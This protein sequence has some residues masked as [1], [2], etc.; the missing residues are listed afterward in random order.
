MRRTLAGLA[1]ALLVAMPV[2]AARPNGMTATVWWSDYQ[3]PVEQQTP[4]GALQPDRSLWVVNSTPC[5][6][7]ADDEIN[8]IFGGT[9]LAGASYTYTT[10]LIADWTGHLI[11]VRSGNPNIAASVAVDGVVSVTQGCIVGPEYER[12]A[13]AGFVA[14][15]GSN[16]GVGVR[17]TV[18][19]TI[20]NLTGRRLHRVSAEGAIE[21]HTGAA[22]AYWCPASLVRG[23][24]YPGPTWYWS[25]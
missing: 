11:G 12:D 8:L 5:I 17:H 13:Y 1:L 20:T 4:G 22:A 6:W 16:G 9:L 3:N 7:D 10:C 14:I 18:A 24:S 25:G 23:G 15:E 21:L 19:W 2:A